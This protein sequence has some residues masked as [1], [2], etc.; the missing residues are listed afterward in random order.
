M[1][2]STQVPVL[3][4]LGGA[5]AEEV[6]LA[7]IDRAPGRLRVVRRCQDL[8]DLLAAAAAGTARAAVVSG[9]LPRLDA[10][11][12]GRLRAAGL[13][14]VGVADR[15]DVSSG[16]RLRALGV[17]T[18][19]DYGAP[20]DGAVLLA[21]L[22]AVLQGGQPLQTAEIRLDPEPAAERGRLVAV[23]GPTGAPGRTAVATTVADEL[24]RLG[25]ETMLADADTYGPSVAQT[26]GLLDEASGLA[27]AVR[28][29]NAG[30]L[31]VEALGGC[32]RSLRPGLRVLTGV[33]RP[34][35][36]PEL[37]GPPLTVVWRTAVA[38]VNR[39]VVDCG[40]CLEQDEEISFDTAAP[41][42]NA[43]TLSSLAVADTVLAVGTADA[44]GL[45]RLIRA[46]PDLRDRAPGAGL[47]V[48]VNHLRRG[49]VGRNPAARIAETLRRHAGVARA[50]FVPFDRDA[51]D[52][53]MRSGRPL[54][55]VARS[56]PARA[57]LAGLASALV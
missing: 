3:L 16:Q 14:V 13:A 44:V 32:A 11:A 7:A 19:V 29:A 12:V 33:T 5:P 24:A 57:A 41:R 23:W 6:L 26:L 53:A 25:V 28:A 51:L 4:A 18:V 8:I 37:G 38:L 1:T 42:R 40:F 43:A 56:S 20:A 52:A 47:H 46:L 10:D 48:V 50:T 36:W 31:D 30:V 17:A 49:A 21:A 45:A 27:A 9:A 55:E 34:D 54:G 22:T 35:R 39:I 2:G 15:T